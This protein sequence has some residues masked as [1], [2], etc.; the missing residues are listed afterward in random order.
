MSVDYEC[1]SRLQNLMLNTA[2]SQS[3][4]YLLILADSNNVHGISGFQI[5]SGI[6]HI[7]HLIAITLI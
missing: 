2:F 6:V 4:D 3:R 5:F 7:R 1:E